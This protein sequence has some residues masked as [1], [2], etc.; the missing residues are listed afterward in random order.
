MQI[1]LLDDATLPVLRKRLQ[2]GPYHILHFIGHG[3]FDRQTQEGV[4]VL[5]DETGRGRLVS[6]QQLGWLVH[7]YRTLA[8]VILNACEGARA[9]RT[10]PFSGRLKA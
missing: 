10:D 5:K 7:N 6:G 1:D 8:L 3:A 2:S 4:V 9:D